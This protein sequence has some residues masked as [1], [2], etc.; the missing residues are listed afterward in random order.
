MLSEVRLASADP[1]EFLDQAVAFANERLGGTLAATLVVH[2]KTLA[3]PRLPEAVERAI[4][5]LR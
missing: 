5:R 2:P 3:E 1:V 4:T